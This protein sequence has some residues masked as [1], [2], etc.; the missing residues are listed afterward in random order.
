MHKGS[1]PQKGPGHISHGP[2]RPSFLIRFLVITHQ[3]MWKWW[4]KLTGATPCSRCFFNLAFPSKRGVAARRCQSF[5]WTWAAQSGVGGSLM[6]CIL[7][8]LNQ[9]IGLRENL[10]ETMVLCVFT[11]KYGSFWGNLSL[12]PIPSIKWFLP[13]LAWFRR[14]LGR[15]KDVAY[16]AYAMSIFCG[17]KQRV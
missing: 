12:K 11:M 7:V 8:R 4:N 3:L 16:W 6:W 2:W 15:L 14:R 10:Q 17:T 1:V 13:V 9:W 5:W